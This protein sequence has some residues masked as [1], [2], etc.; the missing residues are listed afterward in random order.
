MSSEP[1]EGAEYGILHSK[2]VLPSDDYFCLRAFARQ[3]PLS[4]GETEEIISW[5]E[6]RMKPYKSQET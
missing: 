3:K 5:S 4:P 6:P 2:R 1:V